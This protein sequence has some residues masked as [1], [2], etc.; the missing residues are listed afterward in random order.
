MAVKFRDYYEVLSDPAKRAKY[1]ALGPD[2][3]GGQDFTPP[4]GA[5]P[6]GQWTT[7]D[8]SGFEDVDGASDFFAS[9]FGGTERGAR[10]GGRD[11]VRIVIPGGDIEAE[12]PV[13]VEELLHGGRRPISLDGRNLEVDLPVGARDG[14][15][16]RLAGQGQRGINGGPPASR[17]S[18]ARLRGWVLL[19]LLTWLRSRIRNQ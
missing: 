8:A 2:W 15:V 5:G 12:M 7:V 18:I 3:K 17:G 13:T 19:I 16:L 1:D 4:P 14:T 6:T 9:L 11:G 10:R